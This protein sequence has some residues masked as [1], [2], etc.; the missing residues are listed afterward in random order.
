[1]TVRRSTGAAQAALPSMAILRE[2]CFNQLRAYTHTLC[3]QQEGRESQVWK[4]EVW[5]MVVCFGL[6]LLL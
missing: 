3:W 5:P 4:A 2:M 1:M 6:M